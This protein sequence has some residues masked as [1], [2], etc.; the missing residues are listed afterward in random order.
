MTE[1]ERIDLYTSIVPN[2]RQLRI[3]KMKYY[4]FVHYTVNTFTNK[5]WGNGKE[6]ESVF[7]PK[8]QNTDQ[9]CEAIK[10]AGMKGVILTCKHHDGFCLWPTKTTE[11]SVK[12]SPYKK[13]QGR[14][15]ARGCRLLQ[16]IRTEIRRIPFSVGQKRPPLRHTRLQ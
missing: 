15:G 13:R 12:N 9:W 7:N 2:T 3:Q 14:C 1:Q 8:K 16:K 6:P 4:A 10:A 11:H 5:E